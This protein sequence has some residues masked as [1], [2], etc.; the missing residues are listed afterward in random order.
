[1][2]GRRHSLV[3]KE[4]ENGNGRHYWM[5][6]ILDLQT[7]AKTPTFWIISPQYAAQEEDVLPALFK[8]RWFSLFV[9]RNVC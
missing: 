4:T 1:M 6:E 2:L 5:Y 3:V 9:R 7:E 8:L